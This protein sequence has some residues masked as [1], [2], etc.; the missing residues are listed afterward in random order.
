MSYESLIRNVGDIE[1]S[2]QLKSY[3]III[4][5]VYL[6]CNYG[7]IHTFTL[8]IRVDCKHTRLVN[9]EAITATLLRFIDA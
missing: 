4:V 8:Q 9:A 2:T 3:G 6:K 7:G 1:L 5:Y